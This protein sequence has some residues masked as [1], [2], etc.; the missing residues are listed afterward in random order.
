[1]HRRMCGGWRSIR[2]ML[3]LFHAG[4]HLPFIIALPVDKCFLTAW[5]DGDI[6]I[7]KVRGLSEPLRWLDGV[8]NLING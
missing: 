8:A 3:L 1:M 6:E 2:S 5:Y 4:I 7:D